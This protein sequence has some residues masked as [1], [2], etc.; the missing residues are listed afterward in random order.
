MVRSYNAQQTHILLKNS[1]FISPPHAFLLPLS[2]HLLLLQAVQHRLLLQ[3]GKGIAAYQR[4]RGRFFIFLPLVYSEAWPAMTDSPAKP[5][6]NRRTIANETEQSVDRETQ[7]DQKT[8]RDVGGDLSVADTAGEED[9]A[10]AASSHRS[11]KLVFVRCLWL[12]GIRES[13]RETERNRDASENGGQ[14]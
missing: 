7:S 12:Q 8:G 4:F 13:E 9:G 5:E 2:S 10:G 3:G 6:N 1:S 11:L 14:L